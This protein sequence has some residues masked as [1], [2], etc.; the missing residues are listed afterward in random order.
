MHINSNPIMNSSKLINKGFTLTELLIGALMAGIIVAGLG[1]ALVSLLG[2]DKNSQAD[3]ERRVEIDRALSYISKDIRE[4][5]SVS[6]PTGYT[7]PNTTC[8]VNTPVL[9][10]RTRD[11]HINAPTEGGIKVRHTIYY[12]RDISTCS[13]S[14][15]VWLRPGMIMRVSKNSDESWF[16]PNPPATLPSVGGSGTNEL[17]DAVQTPTGGFTCPSGTQT[18]TNGFYACI[19]NSRAVT[20]HIFGRGSRGVTMPGQATRVAVRGR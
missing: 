3:G 17:M 18:G 9:H 12:Y 15:A 8:N 1:Y 14:Q 2:F 11:N 4:A 7:V 19:E 5:Y 10:I 6:V 16:P 20:I 13:A